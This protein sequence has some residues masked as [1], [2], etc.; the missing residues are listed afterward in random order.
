MPLIAVRLLLDSR[1]QNT[2]E[3][4]TMLIECVYSAL[5]SHSLSEIGL[6]PLQNLAL[7]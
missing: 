2:S 5:G 1:P 6:A 4:T 7:I 3:E